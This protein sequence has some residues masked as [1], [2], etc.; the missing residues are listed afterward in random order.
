MF[1]ELDENFEGEEYDQ[2][3][4]VFSPEG[5]LLQVE[6]AYEAVSRSGTIIGMI[7]SEGVVLGAEEMA[8]TLIDSSSGRKIFKIDEHIG[9]AVAGLDS[10]ANVLI[11]E[12]RLYAQS[13]QLLLDEP[14]DIETLVRHICNVK[15]TFTQYASVRPFGVSII[16]GGVDKTG[17]KIFV[18]DPSGSYRAYRAIAI[19]IG[20]ENI[21]EYLGIEYEEQFGIDSAL[22]LATRCLLSDI[23]GRSENQEIKLAT[24]DLKQKRFRMQTKKEVL[25]FVSKS[26]RQGNLL[27]KKT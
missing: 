21:E 11:D 1:E 16:F 17:N 7:C 23:E 20:R 26:N 9:A 3:I 22:R 12:A 14:V 27:Q 24:I 25:E 2:V 8:G 19:G 10:D 4:T 6:Y 5:R 15:Q 18:T 13:Q